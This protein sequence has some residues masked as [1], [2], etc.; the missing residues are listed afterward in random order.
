VSPTEVLFYQDET[1]RAPVVEWLRDLRRDDRRAYAKCVAR[2][3]RLAEAGRELR[4]PE[5]DYSR[6]GIHELRARRGHVNYRILYFFYGQNVAILAHALTK[7][8]EIPGSDIERA[9]RRKQAFERDPARHTYEGEVT[10]G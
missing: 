8:G 10:R 1:R 4:R 3:R 9:I 2:I 6:D 7:E 5:A